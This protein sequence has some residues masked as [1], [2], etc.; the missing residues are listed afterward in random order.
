M[1]VRKHRVENRWV[2]GE[3]DFYI[4][5]ELVAQLTTQLVGVDYA[6]L[7]FLP[8]LYR[9]NDRTRIDLR[10]ITYDEALEK[11]IKIV[12]KKLYLQS[13]NI[14]DSLKVLML[15]SKQRINIMKGQEH[16]QN[17]D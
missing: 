4:G 10:Y 17:Y 12:T 11:A 15:R 16:E 13:M 3:Y 6:Y 7:Y 8:K 2:Y 9:D 1:E 14:L 5:E